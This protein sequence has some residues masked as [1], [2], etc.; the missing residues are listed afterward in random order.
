MPMARIAVNSVFLVIVTSLCATRI[1]CAQAVGPT[2]ETPSTADGTLINI[3]P[4]ADSNLTM[5][6]EYKQWRLGDAG[7][8]AKIIADLRL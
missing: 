3:A 2:G 8:S 1:L 5:G 4:N 6:G 7:A